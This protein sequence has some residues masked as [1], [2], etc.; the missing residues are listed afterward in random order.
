MSSSR[1][2]TAPRVHARVLLRNALAQRPPDAFLTAEE[3][4]LYL[5]RSRGT[6]RNLV[7]AKRLRPDGRGPRRVALFRRSTLDAFIAAGAKRST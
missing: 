4:S 3:A 5:E 7:A 6:I 2:D 1:T